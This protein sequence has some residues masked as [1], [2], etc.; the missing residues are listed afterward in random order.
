MIHSNFKLPDT[1]FILTNIAITNLDIY[2]VASQKTYRTYSTG[3][4]VLHKDFLINN[5]CF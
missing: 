1:E 3:L 4:F 5:D 2:D